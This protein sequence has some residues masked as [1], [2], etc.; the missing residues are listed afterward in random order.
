MSRSVGIVHSAD[1]RTAPE[2]LSPVYS[3][4]GGLIRLHKC[5]KS[6]SGAKRSCIGLLSDRLQPILCIR[7]LLGRAVI[8]PLPFSFDL[9]PIADMLI[10]AIAGIFQLSAAEQMAKGLSSA[11]VT[12]LVAAI[13][14]TTERFQLWRLGRSEAPLSYYFPGVEFMLA[15]VGIVLAKFADY[16]TPASCSCQVPYA[17]PILTI[18]S[19]VT[20]AFFAGLLIL[21]QPPIS[22]QAA[23]I[24][25]KESVENA[26][27]YTP[28]YRRGSYWVGAFV[29]LLVSA[30]LA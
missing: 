8:F 28:S 24:S 13:Q 15:A 3:T 1:A 22:R 20:F 17:G 23:L 29:L 6:S 21:E 5:D 14:A 10:K 19:V 26:R 2:Q 27:H 4:A 11:F 30:F 18:T 12:F 25:I 9:L 16:A 7:G